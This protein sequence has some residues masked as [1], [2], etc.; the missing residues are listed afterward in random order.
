MARQ[1]GAKKR[2]PTDRQ[3]RQRGREDLPGR[4]PRLP[5]LHGCLLRSHPQTAAGVPTSKP[6][7]RQRTLSSRSCRTVRGTPSNSPIRIA[8]I[9]S[10]P[11][12]S[13][14]SASMGPRPGGRG[15]RD[16]ERTA[17]LLA[18]A[19]MGPRPGGR[20]ISL[21]GSTPGH[22]LPVLQWGRAPGGAELI[23]RLV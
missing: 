1:R 8:V 5:A 19:S 18:V 23:P 22:R 16:A 21:I 11:S 7:R 14:S 15:I 12:A 6:P 3:G 17:S 2:C 9:I 20:G 10:T 13:S 4:K